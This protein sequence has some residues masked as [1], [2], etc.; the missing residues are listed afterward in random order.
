M[1]HSQSLTATFTSSDTSGGV[2]FSKSN[3]WRPTELYCVFLPFN[4]LSLPVGNIWSK[5]GNK[6]PS[7][8]SKPSKISPSSTPIVDY[9]WIAGC[10]SASPC[11][12]SVLT[13]SEA[14]P[15]PHLSWAPL[16]PAS[17]FSKSPS[18]AWCAS[19]SRGPLSNHSEAQVLS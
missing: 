12:F 16:H 15:K 2:L 4:S 5:Q 13:S 18:H 9:G 19:E 3:F 1:L 10:Q 11:G 7:P 14:R 8:N 17:G 6:Q